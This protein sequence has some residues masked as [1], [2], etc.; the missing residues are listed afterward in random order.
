MLINI[1]KT[2]TGQSLW[3]G[4]QSF[5]GLARHLQCGISK[6]SATWKFSQPLLSDFYVNIFYMGITFKNLWSL[7]NNST[8]SCSPPW[9]SGGTDSSKVSIT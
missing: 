9:K 6:C 5:H 7:V 1:V 3:E 2:C 4:V 8:F